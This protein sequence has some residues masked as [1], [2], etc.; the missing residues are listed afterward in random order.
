MAP[1]RGGDVDTISAG[2]ICHQ[3]GGGPRFAVRR[4]TAARSPGGPARR[5]SVEETLC[6]PAPAAAPGPLAVPCTPGDGAKRYE[7]V[8]HQ[9]RPAHQSDDP[10]PAGPGRRRRG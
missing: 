1:T 2:D 7:G 8:N 10:D 9:S 6:Y 5:L 4:A 3:I